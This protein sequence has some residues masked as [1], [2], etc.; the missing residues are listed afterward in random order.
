MW[1]SGASGQAPA[2]SEPHPQVG[3]QPAGTRPL[4]GCPGSVGARHGS[5]TGLGAEL[6]ACR[7]ARA[8]SHLPH[9]RPCCGGRDRSRATT[10]K[11]LILRAGCGL[12]G[13][14]ALTRGPSARSHIRTL[15][16]Q[17]FCAQRLAGPGGPGQAPAAPPSFHGPQPSGPRCC[18]RSEG[19]SGPP[20]ACLERVPSAGPPAAPEHTCFAAPCS[21]GP[22]HTRA[23]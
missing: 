16:R 12:G 10:T 23:F 7:E 18:T 19:P 8:G 2:A 14:P 5:R 22:L 6:A 11:G 21:G 15:P 1:C 20:C 13:V 4:P 17:P 3:R 9:S